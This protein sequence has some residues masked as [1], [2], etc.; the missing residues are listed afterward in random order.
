[1]QLCMLLLNI[2]LL[3][4]IVFHKEDLLTPKG[5]VKVGFTK[6]VCVWVCIG[7]GDTF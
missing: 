2:P 7:E 5:E 3:A 4:V 1:M 6:G